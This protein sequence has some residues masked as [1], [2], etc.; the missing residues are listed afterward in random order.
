MVFGICLCNYTILLF[1]NKKKTDL[2]VLFIYLFFTRI[3]KNK[4]LY[5][6]DLCA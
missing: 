5:V 4:H 6:T 3:K 1:N 2:L